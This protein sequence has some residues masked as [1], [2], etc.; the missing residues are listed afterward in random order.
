MPL[1][2]K[3]GLNPVR[4]AKGNYFER[5]IYNIFKIIILIAYYFYYTQHFFNIRTWEKL[6]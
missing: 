4:I 1:A 3:T 5:Q 6:Q 2:V